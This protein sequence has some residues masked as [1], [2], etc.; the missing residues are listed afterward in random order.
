MP[1][2]SAILTFQN[3]QSLFQL[4]VMVHSTCL[5]WVS[6][7]L[8]WVRYGR[9][10]LI[11]W[12]WSWRACSCLQNLVRRSFSFACLNAMSRVKNI[13]WCVYRRGE[14]LSEIKATTLHQLTEH[15][16][17]RK[18]SQSQF[19]ICE[20]HVFY[21]NPTMFASNIGIHYIARSW[22]FAEVG[23]AFIFRC[24]KF[25][26]MWRKRNFTSIRRTRNHRT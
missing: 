23:P 15:R 16:S 22:L 10:N 2:I 5:R 9:P 20:V 19:A 6:W 14:L 13:A 11:I 25:V 8:Y 7:H 24:N 18:L 4:T 3:R 1:I 17:G 26:P 21:A 12:V